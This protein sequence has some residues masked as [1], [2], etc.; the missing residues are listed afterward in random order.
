[1]RQNSPLSGSTAPDKDSPSLEKRPHPPGGVHGNRKRSENGLSSPPSHLSAP[2]KEDKGQNGVFHSLAAAH[3]SCRNG[4]H[5]FRTSSSWKYFPCRMPSPRRQGYCHY[6]CRGKVGSY[7]F[8]L[9]FL[10]PGKFLLSFCKPNTVKAC[11]WNR[12]QPRTVPDA[13]RH[14]ALCHTRK[15]SSNIIYLLSIQ[16][17]KLF[18]KSL[19]K[20]YSRTYFE[21]LFPQKRPTFTRPVRRMPKNTF[22]SVKGGSGSIGS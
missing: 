1:M 20:V 17:K 14:P 5:F 15:A 11:A 9:P 16:N 6:S 3:A 21:H 7:P 12:I 4:F 19:K 10:F 22:T 18:E 2:R 8:H 13:Q